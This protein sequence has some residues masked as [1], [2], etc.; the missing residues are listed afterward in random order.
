MLLLTKYIALFGL[1]IFS[2]E[3]SAAQDP[4]DD[5]SYRNH[6]LLLTADS[7]RI[8]EDWDKAIEVYTKAETLLKE[9][10]NGNLIKCDQCKAAYQKAKNGRSQS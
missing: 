6:P 4:V 10:E 1:I 5:D 2:I 3:F 7:L 9:T 8:I